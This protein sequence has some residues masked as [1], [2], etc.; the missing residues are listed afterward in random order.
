M[1]QHLAVSLCGK[2][3]RRQTHKSGLP[4]HTQA[5]LPLSSWKPLLKAKHWSAE[6]QTSVC[7]RC[8]GPTPLW[9]MTQPPREAEGGPPASTALTAWPGKPKSQRWHQCSQYV[10]TSQQ[11][12]TQPFRKQG[13]FW[14]PHGAV[15]MDL[16]TAVQ[17]SP[18]S[19]WRGGSQ[20]AMAGG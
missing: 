19:S 4:C 6:E 5:F 9:A 14:P 1:P 2:V 10:T 8:H 13:A 11:H 16:P 20:S 7:T 18:S 17:T 12:P 15:H 3:H